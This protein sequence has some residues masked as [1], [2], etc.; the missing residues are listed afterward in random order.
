MLVD[1]QNNVGSGAAQ[2][3]ATMLENRG[4]T[5]NTEVCSEFFWEKL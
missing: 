4:H 1:E 3:L 2:L 5:L